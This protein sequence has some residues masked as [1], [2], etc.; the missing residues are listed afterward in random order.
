ML[1]NGYFLGTG[2]STFTGFGGLGGATG[3]TS[4]FNTQQQQQQQGKLNFQNI[5]EGFIDV[6]NL[7]IGSL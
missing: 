2:Q 3:G 1:L 5:N 7:F 6:L 4:I